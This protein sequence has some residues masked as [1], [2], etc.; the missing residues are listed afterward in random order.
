[1]SD[2]IKYI[3]IKSHSLTKILLFSWD[4]PDNTFVAG[5]VKDNNFM[6][7]KYTYEYCYMIYMHWPLKCLHN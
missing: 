5:Q 2:N 1:M 3:F 6:F 7:S 4:L